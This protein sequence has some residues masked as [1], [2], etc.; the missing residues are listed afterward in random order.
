MAEEA[1]N[2][3]GKTDEHLKRREETF[4]FKITIGKVYNDNSQCFYPS[5]RLVGSFLRRNGFLIG[6]CCTVQIVKK[7]MILLTSGQG[8]KFLE[9]EKRQEE[10][11]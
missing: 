5:I 11:T 1:K 10:S 9:R 4:E 8:E 3:E 7:G 6:D 2:T